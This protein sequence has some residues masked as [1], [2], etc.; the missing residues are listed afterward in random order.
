MKTKILSAIAAG[1]TALLMF[2]SACSQVGISAEKTD[3]TK[4][5]S[6][7]SGILSGKNG[8]GT[9]H[10]NMDALRD[11]MNRFP[12]VTD[13]KWKKVEDGYLAFFFV[14]SNENM[15]AYKRNG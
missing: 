9:R 12:L 11:F 1:C 14:D 8:E 7:E 5:Y 4:F 10:V 2:N 6:V 15:V 13:V 3:S